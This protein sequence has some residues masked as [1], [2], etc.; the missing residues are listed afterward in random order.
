LGGK[1]AISAAVDLFYEKGK[2]KIN[3]IIKINFSITIF[4][5]HKNFFFFFFSVLA[6]ARVNFYF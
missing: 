3:F 4:N 2:K 5:I 6:D 1:D